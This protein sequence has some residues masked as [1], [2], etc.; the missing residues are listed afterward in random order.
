MQENVEKSE[1][2]TNIKFPGVNTR[3]TMQEEVK[4]RDVFR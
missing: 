1:A 2:E 3:Q 4:A